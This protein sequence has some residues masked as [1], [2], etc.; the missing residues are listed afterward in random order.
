[1]TSRAKS[2]EHVDNASKEGT[3]PNFD[4]L[5]ALY[6][7]M[8]WLSFGP[9][10]WWCRC[11]FLGEMRG[12][13]QALVLGDGDGRFTAKLLRT[14]PG[15]QIDAVDASAAMLRALEQRAKPNGTR[16]RTHRA[17]LRTWAPENDAAYDLVITHFFLDCLTTDEI[18]DLAQR[19][20][21]ALAPDAVWMVSEFAVPHGVVGR[22]LAG[23]LVALLYR[24]FGWMTGLGVRRL[25]EHGLALQQAGF[26]LRRE[27]RALGGLLVSEL[28]QYQRQ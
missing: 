27:R 5:A 3:A 4:R 8:E 6:R 26:A 21:P 12:A 28:W 7:W 15:V 11:A 18:V 10:L 2:G 1:M 22:M 20:R 23:S 16:V 14:N 17:N 25:P 9:L 24:A 19:L 13:R